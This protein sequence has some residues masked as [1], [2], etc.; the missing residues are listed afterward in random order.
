MPPTDNDMQG[1]VED[2]ADLRRLEDEE[3]C[4]RDDRRLVAPRRPTVAMR[5]GEPFLPDAPANDPSPEQCAVSAIDHR[6]VLAKALVLV[7]R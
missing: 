1:L 7:H 5:N 2:W 3:D 6:A 4:R